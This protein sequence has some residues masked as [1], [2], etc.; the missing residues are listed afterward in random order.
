MRNPGIMR[1]FKG[2]VISRLVCLSFL[3]IL[4]LN[5]MQSKAQNT[6]GKIRYLVTHNW[7]KEL[8]AVDYLSKQQRERVTYMWG[9]RSEWK[10][11][12]EIYFTPT[13]TRYQ[14][15]EE[16]AEPDDEGYS[17]RRD[18][19]DINRNFSNNTIYDRIQLLGKM[20]I[21]EDSLRPQSW[22]ILNDIKEVAGHICMDA[23]WHDTLK[24]QKVTAWFAM[25]LPVSGGPERL[26][27]LPGMIL[28][29]E[30][31]DG[32]LLITADKIELKT[33][34]TE[35]DLPKK[36]KGKHI[37]EKDYFMVLK[38]HMDDRRKDEEPPFWG[39]RY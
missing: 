3:G 22:K 23:F 29:V 5:P 39:I 24:Q 18:V 10:E 35:M 15:S 13:K 26:C 27:G 8:A 1:L 25:D 11:F 38:K 19:Y 37:Q 12:S 32:A 36:I 2:S 6:E 34:T 33:L 17:W 7:A 21:I 28:E 30:I 9:S 4:F 20:Y 16:R 14:D 31:N